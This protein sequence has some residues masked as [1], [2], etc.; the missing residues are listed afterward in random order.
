MLRWTTSNLIS[1][2]YQADQSKDR[3]AAAIFAGPHIRRRSD[4]EGDNR[5]CVV[6]DLSSSG[7]YLESIGSFSFS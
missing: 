6:Y 5:T 1:A 7:A 3:R 4:A 2:S